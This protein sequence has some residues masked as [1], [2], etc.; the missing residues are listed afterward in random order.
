MKIVVFNDRI[1][2]TAKDDRDITGIHPDC[3]I[4]Y[5]PDDAPVRFVDDSGAP[6]LPRFSSLEMTPRGF[7]PVRNSKRIEVDG[8]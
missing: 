8:H 7:G 1:I 6:V 5:V 3:Q 4:Y 2:S